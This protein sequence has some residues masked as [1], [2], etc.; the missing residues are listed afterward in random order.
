MKRYGSKWVQFGESAAT[1]RRS[2]A[3]SDIIITKTK[4]KAES[5]MY[6]MEMNPKTRNQ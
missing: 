3:R 4:A 6:G 5:A 2:L 1:V